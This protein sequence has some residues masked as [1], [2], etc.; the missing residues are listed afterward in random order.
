MRKNLK[1]GAI[2]ELGELGDEV[3]ESV[4]RRQLL[5]PLFAQFHQK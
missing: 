4:R 1:D 5:R 3:V 2:V